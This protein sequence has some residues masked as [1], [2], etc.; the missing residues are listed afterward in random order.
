[1]ISSYT[2]TQAQG[3]LR[4]A[5]RALKDRALIV[6][7]FVGVLWAVEIIDFFLG[8]A[9]DAFGIR[10]RTLTGLMGIPLAPFLHS[11]FGHLTSNTLTFI[12]LAFLVSAR[13]F[14]HLIGVTFTV[15]LLGGLGVWI[16]GRESSHVGASG[17]IFGYLGFL[18]LSGW[19]DRSKLAIGMSVLVGMSYGGATLS[20][21]L[22]IY[23]GV[24]WESHLFGL[25]AGIFSARI[26][27]RP[28]KG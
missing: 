7:G 3:Q 8:G 15:T 19:Y 6:F 2:Q 9:L 5:Q 20:G 1:M 18:L 25:A 12:P 23:P 10:P 22:P 28:Q 4:S 21:I 17:V 26:F 13:R 27:A 16:F 24:S 11:G 14:G